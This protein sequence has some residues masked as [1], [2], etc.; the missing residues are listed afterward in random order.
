MPR[1][2]VAFLAVAMASAASAET[3]E[4]KYFGEVDLTS[5]E[6]QDTVSSF[7]HRICFDDVAAHL[8]VRLNGTYY[9]YCR[10]DQETIAAW[11]AAESQGRFYNEFVKGRYSCK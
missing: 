8:V 6:C 5:Y 4:V 10:L 3:V 7:V 1:L 2:P 11:L 9:A